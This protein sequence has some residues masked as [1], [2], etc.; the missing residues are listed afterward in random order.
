MVIMDIK[1]V[2]SISHKKYT[3]VDNACILDNYQ[4]L[5]EKGFAHIIRMPLI[6]DVTDTQEN[7][8]ALAALLKDDASLVML[9]LLPYH[10]TAGAK[11]ENVGR[12]YDPPFDVQKEIVI[13]KEIFEAENIRY[14]VL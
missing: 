5:K 14:K 1:L 11:Y 7:A 12:V 10:I 2:D 4:M 9:E 3:G 13:H 8:K 6:P